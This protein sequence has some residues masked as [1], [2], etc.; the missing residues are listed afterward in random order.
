VNGKVRARMHMARGITEADARSAALAD[1]NVQKF[2]EGKEV[3][4]MVFVPDRLINLVV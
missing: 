2:T 4:K 1:E 3:R